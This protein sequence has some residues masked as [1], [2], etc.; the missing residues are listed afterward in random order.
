MKWKLLIVVGLLSSNLFADV[1]LQPV[2]GDNMVLQRNTS[3]NFWGSANSGE[4]VTVTG[5][6]GDSAKTTATE[7]GK[8]K[9]QL[10]TPDAGGPFTVTVQG[11]NKITFKDV[12]SGEV[13]MC[14]GQSNMDCD[15]RFFKDTKEA[16][17]NANH[18]KMRLFVLGKKTSNTPL[19]T[20][21]GRWTLCTPKTAAGFSATGYFFGLKLYKELNIPIGL[22]ECAW[23]GTRVEAWTP[24]E[25]QK[26]NPRLLK[27]RENAAKQAQ[28]YNEAEEKKIYNEAQEKYKVDL[29][30]WNESDKKERAPRRPRFKQNPLTHANY[31]S[32]LYNGMTNPLAPYTVKGAVWYQGESNAWNAKEYA[33]QLELM[34]TAWREKWGQGDFPFYF[35][36]LPGFQKVWTSPV[37]ERA[38][39]ALM[40]E[41][42]ADVAKNVPNTGMAITIDIG[43]A[44]DIHPQQKSKVG[45]RLARLALNKDYG[46]K[47][48]VWTGPIMKSC[49]FKDGKAIVKFETGGPP[50]A[51]RNG[52]TIKGFALCD[53]NYEFIKARAEIVG[54]DTVEVTS[55]KVKTPTIVYYAWA[56]NPEGANL[57]NKKDLPASP[58]RYGKKP[59]VNLM[60]QVIPDK[61]SKQY[62]LVYDIN[63]K[64]AICKAGTQFIYKTDNSAKVKGPFKKVAYFLALRDKAGNIKWVFVEMDPFTD[65]V[66]KIGVPDKASGARFQCPVKNVK[67]KSNVPEIKTGNFPEGCNIEFWD[68]NYGGSNSKKMPGATDKYDFGDGMS[69]KASPGYGSMQIHNN[70]E[71]QSI[72]CFNNFKAGGNADVGIGNSGTPKAEDW[73]FTKNANKCSAAELKVLIKK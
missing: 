49:E 12:M 42:F 53:N 39:W 73:T 48:I 72:I 4:Q 13:W 27:E 47:N 25:K 31:S 67:I 69:P 41:A 26:G 37:E 33:K 32:N 3:A 9:L 38:S 59:E 5:S 28:T 61:I 14:T 18:P 29:K 66:K 45:E 35:V 34:I 52:K 40:R 23:G 44:K 6:W 50:L 63:P 17:A 36:Q 30:T 62:E 56:Q 57:I 7:D 8:W 43:E 22:I 64:S 58:F 16:I 20:L 70:K 19:E 65:D 15:M 11:K 24:W 54:T 68:C 71:K 2:F 51:V 55:K 46:K 10:K 1:K 21:K 60:K